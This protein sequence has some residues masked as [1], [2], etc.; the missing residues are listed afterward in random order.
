MVCFSGH[1]LN[2]RQSKS[3][4]T[5]AGFPKVRLHIQSVASHSECLSWAR[6]SMAAILC[7]YSTLAVSGEPVAFWDFKNDMQGWQANALITD[8]QHSADGLTFNVLS[9]DPFLT[10]PEIDC[11]AGQFLVVTLRMKSTGNTNGQLYFGQQ[12]SENNSRNFNVKNDSQWHDYRITLASPGAGTR[13]RLDPSNTDGKVSVAWMRIEAFVELPMETWATPRELRD[14]KFIGGGLYTVYGEE[15]AITPKFIAQHPEFV[16]SYPFD[17]IVLPAPLS[18]EWV[19]S[20][21]L[22]KMG[23]PWRPAFLNELLWNKIRIP[24]EAV[25]AV[26]NDLK[27]MRRGSLTD[28]FLIFGMVDGA[29][30]LKTPDLADDADWTIVEHNARLA[31]RL[32]RDGKLKGFWLDTEQYGY[33][34]WRTQSGTPEFDPEQPQGLHFPLGKDTPEVLRRRGSQWIKAVQAEF[35]DIKIM[36]T[37]AWSPDSN[38]YGPLTGVIPFLDG[39]L[40]GIE[41]PGHIIHG[42]ENTFYF[43]QP[44]GTTHAYATENGFPGDRNR[45]DSAQAEIRAWSSLSNNPEKYNKFVQVGMAAWIE[46]HPWNLP[47]GWPIGSKASLWSNLPLALAYTDEY[48]WVWSEHTKYGQ[49]HLREVNPFLASLNNQTFNTKREATASFTEDFATD[50]MQCGW[51]FDFDMLAI[52]RKVDPDH[53]AAVMTTKAIPFN[54]DQK[55]LALNVTGANSKRLTGQRRRFVRP[56]TVAATRGSFQAS[57]DFRIDSFGSQQ[58]NPMVLGLFNSESAMTNHSLTLQIAGKDHVNL[59]VQ[60]AGVAVQTLPMAFPEGLNTEQ[61]YRISLDF[62]GPQRMLDATLRNLTL[63]LVQPQSVQT[64][65]PA[66]FVAV[67]L[68][69]CGAGIF[70]SADSNLSPENEYHYRI[71][72]SHFDAN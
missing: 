62:N 56:L 61:T 40:E 55:G 1:G 36:T 30:G 27:S 65:L 64:F 66:A 20:L 60:F 54:W 18:R 16:D 58:N 52:G 67:G 47:D 23:M 42:H 37:F 25:A 63:A 2:M 59:V 51:Y 22:T 17:G 21:G 5:N 48:V 9:P 69:E 33:Y 32:C 14:K 28:N 24:D 31:A 19:N 68:D 12:F 44:K 72:N 35:P 71:I 43:G 53:E 4:D 39:V 11:P 7:C 70:E 26:L 34:R 13:F 41:E 15:S 57:I 38:G 50:P 10:S 49:P 3:A 46:D 6:L 45:Y 29:R 8:S